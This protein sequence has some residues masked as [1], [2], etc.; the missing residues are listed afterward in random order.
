MIRLLGR[1][2]LQ[3]SKNIRYFSNFGGETPSALPLVTWD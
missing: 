1:S 2:A 3:L